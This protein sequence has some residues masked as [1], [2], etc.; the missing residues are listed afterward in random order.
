MTEETIFLAALERANPAEQAAYLDAAC[1]GDP[2][3]RQRVEALL[4]SHAD[5]DSFL[6]RPALARQAG[7]N[8]GAH[9]T[10]E[11]WAAGKPPVGG[12]AADDEPLA[13]LAP[14]RE[15]G[16]LG[17]L[18]H[19][20]VLE[21]VGRGGMGVVF[22][23][24]DTRLQRVVA[25]KVLAAPL[26]AS[27]TARQR[28]F[29]EARAAAA[30][31][32]EHVV[33]IHGVSDE[34][35]PTP[36]LV[37]EF[38]AGI[39][40][41]KRIRERGAL[42]V[43]EVLRI[44]M[45]AALG[46]ASAHRQGLIHRDVKP[47]NILLENGVERVK[48]TDFG[49]AR[50][51]DDA[52]LS[53][54]GVIAGT[55]LYMSPEQARGEPLDARSDLFSLGSV[56]YT[57]CT[58]RAAFAAAT[59]MAVL[60]RVCEETPRPV[61]EVNPDI[62]AWLAAVV[63]RLLAK[64]PGERFQTAA[65][66]AEVLGEHLAQLQQSRL[67]PA[68]A[69]EKP[70]PVLP[71]AVA[72]EPAGRSAWKRKRVAVAAALMVGVAASLVT[73]A[74]LSWPMLFPSRGK[75]PDRGTDVPPDPHVLTV[76]KWPEHRARFNTI[77]AALDEA[78]PG[79]TVR[80]LDDADY[81]EHLVINRREQQRGVVLE[82]AGK[83]TIRKLPDKREAVL[84]RG[85]PGIT[86]RGF[87]FESS[88]GEPH[89]LVFIT[90]LCPGVVLDRLDMTSGSECV[91]LYDMPLT[92]NDAPV[93]IQNC[94]MRAGSERTVFIEGR[95]R[96]SR[97][98][99]PQPCGHVIIRN[100]TLV[101]SDEG[102]VMMGAVHNVEIV[103]NHILDTRHGAILVW[104]LRAGAGDILIANNTMLRNDSALAIADDHAKGKEFLKCKNIRFQNN[105]VLEPQG[106]ADLFLDD[107][108]RGTGGIVFPKADV[109]SLL[110][111]PE[112]RFSHNW[113]E[114]D[115][116]K[117]VARFPGRWIPRC[118]NDQL[119]V[120]I[121]LLSR[122]PGD[123]D[124]LRPPGG[125]RLATGGA[126]VTD[127]AL[128]AYVGAVPPEGV[129]PWD[130]K[131]T[132]SALSGRPATQPA[133]GPPPDDPDVLT[134]SKRPEGGGRFRTIQA[135]LDEAEPGMTIRVL[136]DAVY[137]EYLLIT[138]RHR[139]VVLE[140]TRRATIRKRH[141]DADEAVWIR[142]ASD[143]TLRGF[144]FE[145]PEETDHAQVRI[146]E[147]SAGVELDRLDMTANKAAACVAVYD[148]PL[149]GKD[150]PVVIH[151]CTMRKAFAGIL[152]RGREFTNRDKPQPVGH[153]VIRDNT[154]IHCDIGVKQEGAVHKVLVV[155]NC[156]IGCR[157]C[158]VELGDPLQGTADN[159]VANNTFLGNDTAL[160]IWDEHAKG[161]AFLEC[162]N[163]RIE[164]NLVLDPE[165]DSDMIFC[166]H[167]R[168]KPSHGLP[169][170]L[171][172]LLQAKEAWR[173]DH[174]W[175]EVDPEKAAAKDGRW[176]PGPDDHFSHSIKVLSRTP[177]DPDFLRPPR[178]SPLATGGAGVTDPAL[179]AYVGAVPPEGV[180]PWDWKKTWVALT[181]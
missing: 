9:R 148:L 31:R 54:A 90:G 11:L 164:N 79:M 36:Y 22:K 62:P 15:P 47:A 59:T 114:I 5:P 95:D 124:L 167:V 144:R 109:E 28:F 107:H 104:D 126:G 23:A 51:A 2:A 74:V 17:R 53:Q 123:P 174:N 100:N 43:K 3:L 89:A 56:L 1:A 99:A 48:I 14:G 42:A 66:L 168:G 39:T 77:Q 10:T 150:Y 50:A 7:G 57:L 91:N 75:I 87:G 172:S 135:A 153:V 113:R 94:T 149:S 38:I 25:I 165:T 73:V 40:L 145:S 102:V 166:N 78:G 181:R 67:T 110:K 76:S 33:S 71:A 72:A 86:L 88:T 108:L 115:P 6:D 106:D 159:L 84:I 112:W 175:R 52:S 105:L 45:Q 180:E 156:I 92:G 27:G 137:E 158:A 117:A 16:S 120:P 8:A 170:D 19:Y 46:L 93:V 176:L 18:D 131:K 138:A 68:P 169:G 55:P 41:E 96:Q 128:P 32:D 151:N 103:G 58:G 30:V 64:D 142:G 20:E 177:D 141:D 63:D 82:A 13:F 125:S 139:G 134:V 132:W 121:A 85:V 81:E 118:P 133:K 97:D 122:T 160:S 83:A 26:A 129:E 147:V 69:P 130:W 136:D 157:L 101:Q 60:K 140:A 24:R 171:A 49:L 34:G 37:M 127:P 162:R 178:D 98:Q 65:E 70:E 116:A 111:S 161:K 35:G 173:F 12:P 61:R 80:V 119:Q 154:L 163:V 179:P 155:G 21:L 146:T 29:R 143:V 44:G 152:L 4:R